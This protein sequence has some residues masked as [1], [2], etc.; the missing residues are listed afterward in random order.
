MKKT[1]WWGIGF[2][3]LILAIGYFSFSSSSSSKYD[4][5]A[6]CLTDSGTKMYGAYWCPHC[7]EQKK[8]FGSSWDKVNYVECATPGSNEPKAVCNDAAIKS[9]PTWVFADGESIS[10]GLSLQ[11]L[12]SFTDCPLPAE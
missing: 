1:F 10:G 3:A 11:Q 4:G 7:Q 5:F 6:Q 2:I 12:S 8:L 9:Y